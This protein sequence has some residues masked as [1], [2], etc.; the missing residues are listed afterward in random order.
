MCHPQYPCR[1]HTPLLPSQPSDSRKRKSRTPNSS[2]R[3]K[4]KERVGPG[5]SPI[6]ESESGLGKMGMQME[7]APAAAGRPPIQLRFGPHFW[8]ESSR[9]STVADFCL[10]TE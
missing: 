2:V 4:E 9:G 8:M 7:E 5:S 3:K 6:D 10:S 1:A